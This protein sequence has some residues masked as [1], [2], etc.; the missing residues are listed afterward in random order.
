MSVLVV[1]LLGRFELESGGRCVDS[2]GSSKADELCAFL[3]LRKRQCSR[4]IAGSVLWEG[5]TREQ[6]RVYLRRA[7]W[8]LQVGFR[9]R[10]GVEAS[11]AFD[12]QPNWLSR[13]SGSGVSID[14][15]A[16]A[17][18]YSSVLD[19]SGEQLCPAQAAAAEAA[20][21]SY[22]GEFFE[23]FDASWLIA[24]REQ[25]RLHYLVLLEKLAIYH[26]HNGRPE[27]A[28]TYAEDL[29]E[30]DFVR[31]RSHRLLMRVLWKTGDRI[32]ALQQYNLCAEQLSQ[33]FG[34]APSVETTDLYTLVREGKAPARVG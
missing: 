29:V 25:F 11:E 17:D 16:L 3:L 28:L 7:L 27:R 1:H 2:L 32:A 15:E 30:Y 21:D 12:L 4:D 10:L 14:V 8:Q 6:A 34:I 26:L 19:R 20:V 24:L 33:S 22:N 5:C 18:A 23:S 31:E 9:E 13:V